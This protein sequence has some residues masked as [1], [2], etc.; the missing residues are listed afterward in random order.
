[1][2]TPLAAAHSNH[3]NDKKHY[4]C[5]KIHLSS[6]KYSNTNMSLFK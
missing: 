5:I 1:M 3:R 2:R 4:R 6:K